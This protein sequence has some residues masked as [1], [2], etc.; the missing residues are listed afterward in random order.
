MTAF[1]SRPVSDDEISG[2]GMQSTRR[3]VQELTTH[4][5]KLRRVAKLVQELRADL[6]ELN[7]L[8]HGLLTW[9]K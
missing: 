8:P 3:V 2:E 5:E 4:E 1:E 6:K 9:L 7:F